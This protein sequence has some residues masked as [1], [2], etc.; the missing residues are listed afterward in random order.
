MHLR[1]K[2]LVDLLGFRSCAIQL[3]RT[4]VLP[5]RFAKSYLHVRQALQRQ[6]LLLFWSNNSWP[7]TRPVSLLSVSMAQPMNCILACLKGSR[8]GFLNGLDKKAVVSA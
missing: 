6:P 2:K 5:L 4:S 3:K 1:Q 7:L 8:R